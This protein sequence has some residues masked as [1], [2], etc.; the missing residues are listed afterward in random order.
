MLSRLGQVDVTCKPSLCL[1]SCSSS[2]KHQGNFVNAAIWTATEPCM[3]LVSA[4][5]PSL[6]PLVTLLVSGSHRGPPM[7][8]AQA[9]GSSTSSRMMWRSTNGN[10]D[11]TFTRLEEP[12]KE[13]N[14]RWG[15]SV[16]VRG[17]RNNHSSSAVDNISMEE[18]NVPPNGIKVKTEVVMVTS[19]RLD[20]HDRPY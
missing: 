7:K 11:G 16:S 13:N 12:D 14:H 4:C 17:G 2:N 15:L 5:L 10:E 6:R 8:S 19:D 20:Y 1:L 9:T 18:M 3:G